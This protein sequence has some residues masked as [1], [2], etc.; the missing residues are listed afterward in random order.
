[1]NFWEFSSDMQDHRL[2]HVVSFPN[3]IIGY[4]NQKTN[5]SEI[6]TRYVRELMP[7]KG[8]KWVISCHLLLGL[9]GSLLEVAVLMVR[10]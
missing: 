2:D 8:P 3:L 1:M 6:S 7:L 9:L 10:V 5:L 4:R